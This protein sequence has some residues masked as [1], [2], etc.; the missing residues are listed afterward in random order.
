LG[1]A[2]PSGSPST[3]TPLAVRVPSAG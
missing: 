1:A 3:P 2:R